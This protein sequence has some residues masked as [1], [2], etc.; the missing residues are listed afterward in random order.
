MLAA[1]LL[2]A[3]L[4]TWAQVSAMP[5]DLLITGAKIRTSDPQRPLASALAVREGLIVAIGEEKDVLPWQGMGTKR[6]ALA[7]KTVTPG[8]IDAH[9]HPRA[10]YPE[11]APWQAVEC[12]PDK[13]KS[14]E[15]LIAALRLKAGKT[16]KGH[17]VTGSNYQETLLGRHPTKADLDQAST[18]HPILIRH[19]S[20]HRAVCNSQALDLAGITRDTKDPAGGAFDRD[21]RGEP[22]GIL[23]EGASSIVRRAGPRDQ[24]S[25]TRS[26]QIAGYRECFRRF[27]AAGLTAVHVAGTSED[28]VSLMAEAQQEMP[29]RLYIMHSSSAANDALRR[30]QEKRLGD[31]WIRYGAVKLFHG[32][33]LSGQTA[34]LSEP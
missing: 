33:S 16:P 15:E 1:A 20:G 17:W 9:C 4:A 8:F 24:Q 31:D 25:P 6:L 23:K 2:Y 13:I 7:G 18:Q 32:N 30:V 11:D 34:W 5:A 27:L 12:G 10:I 26:Q 14:M 21:Q 29:V 22:N 3:T 28:A 19:S